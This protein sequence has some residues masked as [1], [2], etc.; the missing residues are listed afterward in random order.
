VKSLELDAQE[1]A[2]KSAI[3]T[4]WAI[5]RPRRDDRH[6]PR[7]A[8]TRRSVYPRMSSRSRSRAH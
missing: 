5:P 4:H 2:R 3:A 7:V 1:A 6:R 8:R